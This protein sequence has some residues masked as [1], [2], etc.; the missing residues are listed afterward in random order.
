MFVL[1]ITVL[2]GFFLR[3]VGLN[4]DQGLHIH[5]DERMLIMVAQNINF[6]KNLDP[7]FFNY[8][9]L[10]IYL[11]SGGAQ[12]IHAFVPSNLSLYDSL[13]PIGRVFSMVADILVIVLVQRL[14]WKLF[15][16]KNI[17]VLSPLLY[18]LSFFP[19]QNSHFFIVDTFLTLFLLLTLYCIVLYFEK[20][21]TIRLLFIA[22]AFAAAITTKVTPIIFLPLIFCLILF[23]NK[24]NIKKGIIH[25]VYC[26]VLLCVFAFIFMP[27]AFLH[28]QKFIA[29]ISVQI[30]LSSD[31]YVF[32]YTLQYV[33]ATPYL[34]YLK[35]IFLWGLG[36]IISLLS[37]VGLVRLLYRLKLNNFRIS[38]FLIFYL[39]FFLL[40][41]GTAVKFM[42]YMLPIY[43]FIT[44][45]AGYGLET[46]RKRTGNKNIVLILLV[47]AGAWTVVFNS[48][49]LKEHSRI[50][51]S[52]WILNNIPKKSVLAVE[53]W[54][55][56]LPANSS[57]NY[58][59][60]ELQLYNQ[61]DDKLKWQKITTQLT[62][63]DYIIIASNRLYI[64]LQK[65]KTCKVFKSC[66]P[67]TAV[68]YKNL[69]AG[70]LG[71]KKVAEFSVFPQLK[72][73]NF[74]FQIK[75]TYADESFTVYDHP[76]IFIFKRTR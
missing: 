73:G 75:D 61:P 69:F 8:G 42:R 55:D 49:Y 59:F 35:N 43:P 51:A 30:K 4:W 31:P 48:I 53:H 46:I 67:I 70:N 39:Y 3:I 58:K 16:N 34:Y 41:G 7:N 57:E 18:A 32:P 33:G 2:L 37:L 71:F 29:D 13:L 20:T 45:L 25:A 1:A 52:N 54:D 64:P 12:L 17:S 22:I 9:S 36:P 28:W 21:T 56:R 19:I 5:P 68:Y 63:T 62:K 26:L 60:E 74:K 10:P 24:Q 44:I 66:Y 50:T 65:L 14:S 47:V 72:I 76:T 15:K 38:L 27:F 11:L 23:K 6:F 40:L